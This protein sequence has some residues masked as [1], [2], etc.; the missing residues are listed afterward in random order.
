[1][2]RKQSNHKSEDVS[3][4]SLAPDP[5]LD[6][7]SEV[8]IAPDQ[9]EDRLQA[10]GHVLFQLLLAGV[11]LAVSIGVTWLLVN[12]KTAPARVPESRMA[13]RVIVENVSV[14]E[15]P[16]LI[17]GFGSVRATRQLQ[18]VPQVGG[19]VIEVSPN[20]VVGGVLE[21][22]ALVLRIDPT[23]YE[24]ASQSAKAD[25]TRAEA[26]LR[27][28]ESRRRLALAE[29]A[30]RETEL[31]TAEAE[32][33]VS[34]REFERL[35]PGRPVPALVAREP[36]LAEAKAARSAAMA[37]AE[38]VAVEETELEAQLAQAQTALRLAEVNLQRT[39][40]RVPEGGS[41]RVD[42]ESVD[43]GQT[44][45]PGQSLAQVWDTSTLEVPVPLEDRQLQWIALSSES[46]A[47][48]SRGGSTGAGA[49]EGSRARIVAD[50]SGQ[51]RVWHGHVSR[52]EGTIDPRTRMVRVI[53]AADEAR[54]EDGGAS[55]V[56]G[57]FVEVEIEG[58]P[59]ADVAAIP[60]RALRRDDRGG[61]DVVYIADGDRL[62][63]VPVE[64][65]RRSGDE[66][67]VR[68]LPDGAAVILTRLEIASEGMQIQASSGDVAPTANGAAAEAD[69]PREE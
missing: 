62:R 34:R 1:M 59:L 27:R 44:V 18:L 54:S 39:E 31:A 58:E 60:R 26:A 53:V 42:S 11:V 66:I 16:T 2:I 46:A 17:R 38:D 51:R 10:I 52:T 9:L 69:S 29:V 48:A 65:A 25:L 6:G 21:G 22:G 12:M 19:R 43:A 14:G 35:N 64:V 49:S 23:D 15:A 20:L 13:P 55:L 67:Y 37:A 41:W 33:E 63:I 45:L 61:R 30:R 3:E 24:L 4:A 32:A 5:E 57:A 36:Q 8:Q 56:P 40:L 68:G 47:A 28:I 7:E 50:A